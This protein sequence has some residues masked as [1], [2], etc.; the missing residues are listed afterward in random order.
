MAMV[1][2]AGWLAMRDARAHDR[3]WLIP[4]LVATLLGSAG[5]LVAAAAFR[6]QPDVVVVVATV[7]FLQAPLV[8]LAYTLRSRFSRVP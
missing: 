3:S 6:D 2:T 5:P 8:A 1:A 4:L 7:L